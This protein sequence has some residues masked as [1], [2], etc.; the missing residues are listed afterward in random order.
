M[1]KPYEKPRLTL[2]LLQSEEI[3]TVSGEENLDIEVDFHAL[4]RQI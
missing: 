3:L 2:L 4:W 1:N